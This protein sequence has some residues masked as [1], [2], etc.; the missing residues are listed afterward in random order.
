MQA[1]APYYGVYDF[2]D[3]ENMHVLMLP[4][5]EQFVMKARYADEP[6]RF[7]AASPVSYVHSDA[8][9]FFVLHGEKDELVP[10]GQA[11]AF[12]S[13]LRAAG[14]ATVAPRRT[15]QRSPRFRHHAYGAVAAGRRRRRRFPWCRL[16]AARQLA[17][18]FA[19][20]SATSA[21]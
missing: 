9:P 6:E 16:W 2:T 11:R 8:P 3:F 21:S 15:R 5:L 13:A 20:L 14:A 12:C 19:A 7:T 4:F 17:A 1:V 10:S 18:G